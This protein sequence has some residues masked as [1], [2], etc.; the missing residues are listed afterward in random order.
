VPSATRPTLERLSQNPNH[1]WTVCINLLSPRC[2]KRP[3]HTA[4]INNFM[5]K[6]SCSHC[7]NRHRQTQIEHVQ[8]AHS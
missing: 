5:K 4:Q 8:S 7:P 6:N 1:M 3:I 2:V